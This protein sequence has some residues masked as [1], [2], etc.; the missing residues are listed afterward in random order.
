MKFARLTRVLWVT[1]SYRNAIVWINFDHVVGMSNASIAD[2]GGAYLKF[3]L[4]DSSTNGSSAVPN[5]GVFGPVAAAA[6]VPQSASPI[7]YVPLTRYVPPPP[8]SGFS[9]GF[10]GGFL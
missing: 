8:G 1:A 2:G 4:P 7:L 6:D 10:D 5:D 9:S 3:L